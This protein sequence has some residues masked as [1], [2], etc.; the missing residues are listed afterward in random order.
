MEPAKN[1]ILNC[2]WPWLV[3]KTNSISQQKIALIYI[4]CMVDILQTDKNMNE[5][6]AKKVIYAYIR[7]MA[8]TLKYI[9]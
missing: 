4:F 5:F 8:K 7:T 6:L 9:M 1:T 3:F 2:Q